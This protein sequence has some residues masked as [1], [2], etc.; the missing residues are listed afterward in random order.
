MR[1]LT[2]SLLALVLGA[3]VSNPIPKDYK[4]PLSYI[5]DSTAVSETPGVDFFVLDAVNGEVIQDSITETI[6]ANHGRG[7]YMD[8]KVIGR[9]VPAR[10]ATFTLLGMTHYAAPILALTNTVY[11]VEG[12]ITFTPKADTNYVVKGKLGADYSA[13]WLENAASGEQVGEKI[14]LKGSSSLGFFEK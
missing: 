10:K 9:P 2:V 13:V 11:K 1:A 5:T 6:S 7:F 3:C 8:P 12:T 4:G 14:E